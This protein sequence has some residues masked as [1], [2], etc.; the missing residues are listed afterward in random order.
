MYVVESMRAWTWATLQN[1]ADKLHK[2]SIDSAKVKAVTNGVWVH[3][4]GLR[5]GV[6]EA[7]LTITPG[8][9]VQ[10]PDW[11]YIHLTVTKFGA[12][13]AFY[14]SDEAGDIERTD[15]VVN[16]SKKLVNASEHNT[17]E[18]LPSEVDADV[19]TLVEVLCVHR[20]MSVG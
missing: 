7:H 4:E 16:K 15:K 2:L 6:Y 10:D 9:G 13:H 1:Y 3:L 5:Y 17:S 18:R 12:T 19:Q 8:P 20:W 14:I 11:Q